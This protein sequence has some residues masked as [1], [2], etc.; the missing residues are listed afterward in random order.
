M[1]PKQDSRRYF[2][3][4]PQELK[5]LGL[6]LPALLTALLAVIVDQAGQ[7]LMQPADLMLPGAF[8]VAALLAHGILVAAG[9]QADATV[10]PIW[11][12]IGGLGIIVQWRL[13]AM[14][15]SDLL[16]PSAL[17]L[18]CSPICLAI[19]AVIFKGRLRRFSARIPWFWILAAVAASTAMLAVGNAYRG[20]IYGPGKTT[21]T[22]VVKP[23]LVLGLSGLLFRYG[24]ALSRSK[25][26]W[27]DASRRA[28]IIIVGAWFLIAV[29]LV[30]LHDLGML[31]ATGILLVV[32][33]TV[34]SGRKRYIFAG[35][36]LAVT[37]GMIFQTFI[38]KGQ[39]RFAAWLHPFD[40][41]DTSGFQIIR[42]LFAL[43]N[44]EFFGR[45]IGN[46]FPGTIP[47]AE[48]DF[49]YSVIAEEM[50]WI[51]SVAIL[52]LAWRICRLGLFYG[53]QSP[54][55][56]GAL[57]AIGAGTLWGTQILLHVGG[58]IKLIPMT[59]VPLPGISSGG[60]AA[61]VFSMMAGWIMAVSETA[62]RNPPS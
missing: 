37:G 44:G 49:T 57:I 9:S 47:L 59:G 53:R 18:I 42:S 17:A 14:T 26:L 23:L 39:V 50:G 22:E 1:S 38:R 2:R 55:V 52:L 27:T 19:N 16:S 25:S 24:T 45:G 6:T 32:L 30:L 34:T 56:F 41:P 54:D 28:H 12:M 20:G 21:P 62:S 43:F 51:G 35:S 46:G 58:V 33:L 3:V 7:R 4:R 60:T 48:T 10:L 13:N 8:L 15:G 61:L 5:L 40:H 11:T 31:A 36:I 29:F